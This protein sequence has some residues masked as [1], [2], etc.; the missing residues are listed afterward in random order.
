MDPVV[1]NFKIN[2]NGSVARLMPGNKALMPAGYYAIHIPLLVKSNPDS[3]SYFRKKEIDLI[4]S[5]GFR[6]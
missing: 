5:S 3:L 4:I 6:Q 2:Q 1:Y